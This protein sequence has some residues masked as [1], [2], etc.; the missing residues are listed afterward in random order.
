MLA[1]GQGGL[2]RDD[3]WRE[4]GHRVSRSGEGESEGLG[5]ERLHDLIG[6]FR[7]GDVEHVV[8]AHAVP[9]C[10]EILGVAVF[11]SDGARPASGLEVL[12]KVFIQFRDL[13]LQIIW[14]GAPCGV[15]AELL[16]SPIGLGSVV[17]ATRRTGREPRAAGIVEGVPTNHLGRNIGDIVWVN[18][19]R[20]EIL[21][22]RRLV[23]GLVFEAVRDVIEVVE[24]GFVGFEGRLAVEVICGTVR[25]DE[26]REPDADLQ[27]SRL[28]C[29]RESASSA[30]APFPFVDFAGRFLALG[31]PAGF[32]LGGARKDGIGT[33]NGGSNTVA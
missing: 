12:L 4:Q 16:G 11:G 25:G 3:G 14:T 23:L 20:G 33:L 2:G 21:R 13:A 18:R 15:A 30:A 17:R 31:F 19:E 8:A 27:A 1:V 7:G 28:A 22:E 29:F 10:L 6:H 26:V 24:D 32:G 9:E 5:K